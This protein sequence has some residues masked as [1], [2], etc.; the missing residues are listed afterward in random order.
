MPVERYDVKIFAGHSFD[1]KDS[2]VVDKFVKFFKS[3]EDIEIIT[4]ER[5]QDKSVAQ[6]VKDRI[7]ECDDQ[8][9]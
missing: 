4:G 1:D 3:R 8:P 9:T 7:N 6:K 5:A 2:E